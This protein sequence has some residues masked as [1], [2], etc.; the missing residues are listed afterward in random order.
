VVWHQVENPA[1]TKLIDEVMAWL[2]VWSEMQLIYHCH[3]INQS[4]IYLIQATRPI[5]RINIKRKRKTDKQK[6][7]D[8]DILH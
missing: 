6:E 1:C 7:E 4:I 5:K 8:R 3:P 2:S